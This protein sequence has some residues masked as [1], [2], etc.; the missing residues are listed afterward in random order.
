MHIWVAGC[1]LCSLLRDCLLV[2]VLPTCHLRMAL[3]C[4]KKVPKVF[5]GTDK[6]IFFP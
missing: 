3:F 6:P 1:M 5:S 4:D 2:A